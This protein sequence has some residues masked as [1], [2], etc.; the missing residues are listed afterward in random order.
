[1]DYWGAIGELYEERKRLDKVIQNLEAL[2]QGQRPAPLSHRGRKSMT[3]E[4]RREVSERMRNYW[5]SRRS[6]HTS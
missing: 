1:M 3:E 4:E 2:T 6:S 5:A